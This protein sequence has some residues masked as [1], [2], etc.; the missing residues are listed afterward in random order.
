MPHD[1]CWHTHARTRMLLLPLLPV[2]QSTTWA[3]Q[4]RGSGCPAEV[5][6]AVLCAVAVLLLMPSL[7]LQAAVL[8]A[9]CRTPRLLGHL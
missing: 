8:Q 1:L 2:A 7:I 6:H 9:G 5:W 4:A 3:R